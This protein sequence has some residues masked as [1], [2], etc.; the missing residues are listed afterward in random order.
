MQGVLTPCNPRVE[1]SESF[2]TSSQSLRAALV[3]L[4][5]AVP[6]WLKFQPSALVAFALL[7][8][9]SVVVA[10]ATLGGNTCAELTH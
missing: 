8:H 4:W 3:A 1:T 7:I 6:L 10:C 5:V 9:Q 2:V